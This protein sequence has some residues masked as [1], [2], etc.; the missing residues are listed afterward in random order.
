MAYRSRTKDE[1]YDQEMK[2]A[3]QELIDVRSHIAAHTSTVLF[4]THIVFSP[5]S[6]YFV[7]HLVFAFLS[8][9]CYC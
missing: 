8:F 7:N 5:P 6:P 2:D 9:S 1:E 4:L 3:E